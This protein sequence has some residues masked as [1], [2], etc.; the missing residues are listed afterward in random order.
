[1]KRILMMVVVLATML[2]S[3]P[4]TCKANNSNT[5]SAFQLADKK[6]EF[7]GGDEALL[8]Y[9]LENI[10]FSCL[11][12]DKRGTPQ[13]RVIVQFNVLKSGQIDNVE[14]ESGVTPNLDKE[15]VRVVE[16]MPQW[17]PAKRQGE[18]I[19]ASFRLAV[20]FQS[21]WLNDP[22]YDYTD[23]VAAEEEPGDIIF[24]IVMRFPEFP[25]GTS[26]LMRF[27][28]H[29]LQY[30]DT[31]VRARA[32]GRVVVKFVIKADGRID[33][34]QICETRTRIY[35]MHSNPFGMELLDENNRVRRSLE[36]EAI[37]V[38]RRMPNWVPGKQF[39]QKVN[40][41]FS[42]PVSFSKF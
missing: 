40:V 4:I 16:A 23:F 14:I 41:R 11:C 13:G 38:V 17:I 36:R 26:A 12:S 5:D 22:T 39:G 3:F 31:A 25:G 33:D 34:I 30:P 8:Q 35:V 32:G 20:N 18:K 21:V 6:P 19:D 28:R 15:V 42:L 24:P 2:L 7:P 10:R 37:R 9:L 29:N 27:L 1:M